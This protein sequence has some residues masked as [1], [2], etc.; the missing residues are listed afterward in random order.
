[1]S[2]TAERL[3]TAARY[4]ITAESKLNLVSFDNLKVVTAGIQCKIDPAVVETL[5]PM[6]ISRF[7]HVK[8]GEI[9]HN[10]R[11]Y[12]QQKLVYPDSFN[13]PGQILHVKYRDPCSDTIYKR[14]INRVKDD[15]EDTCFPNNITFDIGTLHRIVS[16]KLSR[17]IV[18]AGIRGIDE[19]MEVT[20][21]FLAHLRGYQRTINEYH[22]TKDESLLA[23]LVKDRP[24]NEHAWIIDFVRSGGNL[25]TSTAEDGI[26]IP[27][28]DYSV[29]MIK[30]STHF[31]TPISRS[32]LCQVL[33]GVFKI[34]I[35]SAQN[36]QGIYFR[37]FIDDSCHTI[38]INQSGYFTYI[39]SELGVDYRS[40]MLPLYN[41]L[42]RLIIENFCNVASLHRTVTESKYYEDAYARENEH[43]FET[44]REIIM[45]GPFLEEESA[46][47]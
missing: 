18:I 23:E 40:K 38:T 31:C 7:F 13:V 46:E 43:R 19:F 21:Y 35:S 11:K 41:T 9:P 26:D 39:G 8:E 33:R 34:N 12:K 45:N 1:M 25:Y 29:N 22:A 30:L 20:G 17:S 37:H 3:E 16:V 6:A 15:K 28:I 24:E 2:S 4:G 5:N 47:V 44:E 14:G 27:L 42:M 36:T 32:H 10:Q